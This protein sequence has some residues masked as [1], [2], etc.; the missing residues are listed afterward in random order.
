[1]KNNETKRFSMIVYDGIN[2]F[3]DGNWTGLEFDSVDE[4]RNI[5][6]FLDTLDD[7]QADHWIRVQQYLK[8]SNRTFDMLKYNTA[9]SGRTTS[10]HH[11]RDD[12]KDVPT[13]GREC[14][15]AVNFFDVQWS[16]CPVEVEDEV[17]R[18][19]RDYELGNDNYFFKWGECD[20]EEDTYPIIAKYLKSRG[21]TKCH[22]HWWW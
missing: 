20:E 17:K 10:H 5:I 18:L 21:I 6:G 22:I 8:E 11:K 14:I 13:D 7:E 16:N 19:W 15:Q 1:M 4:G 12:W 2:L 9:Y 3:R